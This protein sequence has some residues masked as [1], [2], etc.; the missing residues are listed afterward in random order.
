LLEDQTA[1]LTVDSMT[2]IAS[3]SVTMAIMGA[4]V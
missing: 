4:E 2:T 1:A 3:M